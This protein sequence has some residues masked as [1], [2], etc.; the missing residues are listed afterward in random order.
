[1]PAALVARLRQGSG[2]LLFAFAATHLLNHALGLHSLDLLEAGRRVFLA[3]WRAPVLGWLVPAALLLHPALGLARL[4]QRRTLHVAPVELLQLGLGLAIPTLLALHLLGTGVAHRLLGVRDDYAYLLSLIWPDGMAR[5]SL[6]VVLVWTHGCIGVHLW[7]RLR[8]GYERWSTPLACAAVLLP[9]L[10]VLGTISAGRELDRL[11]EGDPTAGGR[12][13][14]LAAQPWAEA[15]AFL[16]GPVESAVVAGWLALL[17]VLLLARLLR[18]AVAGRHRVAVT[19]D[20]GRTI[21]VPIGLTLLEASRLFGIPH[22]SVCGGRARCST[23]RVRV[24]AG[25]AELSPPDPVEARLLER[26]RAPGDVRLACRIRPRAPLRVVRL[27][28]PAGAARAVLRPMDPARGRECEIAVLFAD[29][30]GFTRLAERRLPYDVVFVLNRFVAVTG[31]AIERAGGRVD[32]VMGDGIMALFGLEE[33]PAEA[34]RA[35]LAAARGMGEA[36]A[37]LDRELAGELGEP[38]RMG[39]GLHLGP[40]IVGELGFGRSV[41]LTAIGDTVNVASRLE[42]L[43]KEFGVELVVSEAL[44]VAAGC[45]LEASERR[46]VALRGRSE[47]LLVRLVP[48]AASLPVPSPGPVAGGGRPS[49]PVEP[50]A[51]DGRGA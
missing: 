23:C 11:R 38:L 9:T 17:A 27:V 49:R 46:A 6:L 16:V 51:R 15:R 40:A 12:L 2:L 35:A 45:P 24:T 47:P 42:A 34:A 4:W 8:A 44:L 25:L 43:T 13:V 20:G 26:V 39:I 50:A 21:R 14:E 5:Q 29:L 33:A 3:L 41:H 18:A 36:L 37:E 22:A 1:M 7:L 32:K 30:R 10:A 28:P 48:E 31:A 19:F